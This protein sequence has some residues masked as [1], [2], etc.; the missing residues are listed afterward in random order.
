MASRLP[1]AAPAVG[2]AH[3]GEGVVVPG[4]VHRRVRRQV[5]QRP[6]DAGQV[7][8][9]AAEARVPGAHRLDHAQ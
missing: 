6:G 8:R 4:R 2:T 3:E 5:Q 9:A 7:Q 1:L